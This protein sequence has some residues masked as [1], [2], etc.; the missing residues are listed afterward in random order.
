MTKEEILKKFPF[1]Q[2]AKPIFKDELLD[3]AMPASLTKGYFLFHEGDLCSQIALVG[4]GRIRV[5]KSAE[6]GREITLYHVREGETCIL[7]ASCILSGMKYPAHAV[8]ESEVTGIIFPAARFREWIAT[9]ESIRD[10]IFKTLAT[11][12]THMMTLVEEI[13]FNKME[14]RLGDYLIRRFENEG[15]PLRVLNLTHEQIATDLGSARKVVSRLLKDFE[16]QGVIQLA[17]GKIVLQDESR[18]LG[19]R[20]AYL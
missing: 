9:R 7:S 5:Y 13:T 14:Q 19:R 10:F 4:K 18:M 3:L 15:R 16:R 12:M 6:S 11:R 20:Q 1:F 17:R 2:K 8:A